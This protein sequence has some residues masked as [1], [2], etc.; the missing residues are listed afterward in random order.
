MAQAVGVVAVAVE[1]EVLA[2]EMEWAAVLAIE[3][4][5]AACQPLPLKI[6]DNSQPWVANEM[7]QNPCLESL[8]LSIFGFFSSITHR[9]M[10][11][12]TWFPV[13]K[14]LFLFLCFTMY[15]S[16]V[17]LVPLQSPLVGMQSSYWEFGESR[18]MLFMTRNC[19]SVL[20]WNRWWTLFFQEKIMKFCFFLLT[21]PVF[22]HRSTPYENM[23]V[24]GCEVTK[25]KCFRCVFFL[26][27]LGK[28]LFQSNKFYS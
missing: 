23:K 2:I 5:W 25:W 22:C 18:D 19:Y 1:Q 6:P 24:S 16:V 11:G 12:I 17:S 13:S 9:K 15:I 7:F 10:T 26:V 8:R 3:T 21:S 27:W 28:T 20:F 14:D 4:E